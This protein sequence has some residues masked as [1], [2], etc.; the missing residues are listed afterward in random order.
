V[1]AV[2]TNVL[3]RYLLADDAK[4]AAAAR[5][6]LENANDDIWIPITVVLELAWVLRSAGAPRVAIA[7]KLRELAAVP[8]V[9]VQHPGRLNQALHWSEQ[10][11]DLADALHLA[12]SAEASRFVTFDEA[13][14]A[15]VRRIGAQPPVG[16]S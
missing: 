4:Q 8:G 6:L 10:G 3:A 11:I 15:G 7:M 12:L 5:K 16:H 9:R 2:D 14:I 13:L 1:I